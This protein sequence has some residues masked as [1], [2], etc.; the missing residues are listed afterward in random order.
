MKVRGLFFRKAVDRAVQ[1]G[2]IAA[3]AFAIG[4]MAWILVTVFQYGKGAFSWSFLV[5]PSRPYGVADGGIANALLGTAAITLGAALLA[6]PPALLAG[7][8]LAEF[9]EYRKLG[10]VLRFSAN[11]MMGMPSVLVGLFVYMIWV[12][13]TGHF[14]GFAAS[15][16]L[17]ILMFP[18]VM[19]TTEDMLCMVPDSLREAALALGMTRARACL[20]VV[21]RAAR[22]GLLTGML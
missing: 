15:L 19:R 1:I 13:P 16:A 7:I 12:V 20:E 11:V 8:A 10:A 22:G 21:C 3:V 14:S 6:L 5:N 4:S 2:S 9:K 18:V 17:A